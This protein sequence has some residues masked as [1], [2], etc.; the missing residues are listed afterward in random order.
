M[1]NDPKAV[2]VGPGKLYI[3]PLGTA[4][5]ADLTTA[6]NAAFVALGYTDNGTEIVIDQTFEDVTVHEELEPV[7][8]AQTARQ[9]TVNFAA[10]EITATNLQR[11]LNG[12]TITSGTG[13][14][15]FEPP[16]AG[17]YTPVMLGW[18][19]DDGLERFVFRRCIN[20]GSTTMARRR[21]PDKATIGMSFR[22][23]KPTGAAVF[24]YIHD[25]DYVT[26]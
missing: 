19:S 18:E 2:R 26:P 22:C 8:I 1:P 25:T 11:A 12:G 3:A 5:P 17:V 13:I 20:T 23:T 16:A 21:A 9:V 24:K 10:A 6:W 4:E 15:T 14:V 7:E